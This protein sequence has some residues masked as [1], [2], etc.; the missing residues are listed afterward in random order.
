MSDVSEPRIPGPARGVF[1]PL[2]ALADGS[3]NRRDPLTKRLFD[4]VCAAFLL[5]FLAPFILTISAVLWVTEGGPVFF[6]QECVGL[7]GRGFNCLKFRTMVPH[8]EVRLAQ[9]LEADP[10]ARREWE[11]TRKLTEDP[12]ISCLGNLL[13]RSSL[14][15]LPQLINVLRGEMSLVGSRPVVESERSFYGQYFDDYMSV[16]PRLTGVWQVNGRSDTTYDERVQMDVEYV[17]NRSFFGD[18]VILW[19]TAGVV[20]RRKGA[21]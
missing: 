4:R 5:V 19:R 7:R 21:G 13:R 12:R 20:L 14:D 6:A 11:A 8:A 18:L 3:A 15:E 16:R 17:R 2:D 10:I 1:A 9:L